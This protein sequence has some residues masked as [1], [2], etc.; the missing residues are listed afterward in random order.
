MAFWWACGSLVSSTSQCL[1][2]RTQVRPAIE[3]VSGEEGLRPKSYFFLCAFLMYVFTVTWK[4]VTAPDSYFFLFSTAKYANMHV[5]KYLVALAPLVEQRGR[6]RRSAAE[7]LLLPCA[8][9]VSL[10]PVTHCF[11]PYKM[12]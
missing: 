4:F 6:G 3:Y 1:S 10:L 11:S 12:S 8:V 2:L 5:L 9:V 7:A